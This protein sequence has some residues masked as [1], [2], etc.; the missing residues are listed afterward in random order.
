MKSVMLGIFTILVVLTVSL[1]V[2]ADASW[3]DEE[4]TD[5]NS[6]SDGPQPIR[7]SSFTVGIEAIGRERLYTIAAPFYSRA[8]TPRLC[9]VILA[10]PF[11]NEILGIEATEKEY[12]ANQR[13]DPETNTSF[14]A[15]F[16]LSELPNSTIG[17][18]LAETKKAKLIMTC[19][20][21]RKSGTIWPSTAPTNS[22]HEVCD[23]EDDANMCGNTCRAAEDEQNNSTETVEPRSLACQSEENPWPR[24]RN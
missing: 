9:D 12:F 10:V 6:P 11:S 21:P 7:V 15:T 3:S 18:W 22:P 16:A 23:P 19:L 13:I 8:K 4:W 17:T 14:S 20:R 1:S 24:L 5:D 2:S